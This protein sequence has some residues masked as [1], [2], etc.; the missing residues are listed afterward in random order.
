MLEIDEN[1]KVSRILEEY[2]DIAEVMEALGVSRIGRWSARRLIARLITVKTAA[3]VHRVP[4]ERFLELL[5]QA[6]AE[7]ARRNAAR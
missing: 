4:L 1:T 3:R 7:Q 6:V 5:R 2:G